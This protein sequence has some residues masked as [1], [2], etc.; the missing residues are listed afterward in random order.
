MAD[1]DEVVWERTDRR[2]CGAGYEGSGEVA[3]D[4][5]VVTMLLL[6]EF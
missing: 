4:E 3:M 1:E 2:E 5:S 6:V